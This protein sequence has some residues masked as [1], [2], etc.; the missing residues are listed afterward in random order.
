MSYKQKVPASITG[1]SITPYPSTWCIHLMKLTQLVHN[2]HKLCLSVPE[3]VIIVHDDYDSTLR[4]KIRQV[5]KMKVSGE[6]INISRVTTAD[7]SRRFHVSRST[8]I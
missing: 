2:G 3:I 7:T 6:I 8:D 5:N 4:T 1:A